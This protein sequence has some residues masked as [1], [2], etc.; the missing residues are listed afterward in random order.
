MLVRRLANTFFLLLIVAIG[1]VA[2]LC[3]ESA[4][5]APRQKGLKLTQVFG[6]YAVTSLK[7][8]SVSCSEDGL[9]DFILT[10]SG[11][12]GLLAKESATL[13]VEADDDDGVY[14]YLQHEEDESFWLFDVLGTTS[15]IKDKVEFVT[16]EAYEYESEVLDDEGNTTVL[17]E[18]LSMDLTFSSARKKGGSASTKSGKAVKVAGAVRISVAVSDFYQETDYEE[19]DGSDGF[20]L[21]E[22]IRNNRDPETFEESDDEEDFVEEDEEPA[23]ECEIEIAFVGWQRK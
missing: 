5:A 12:A 3:L 16:D 1:G 22:F 2:S 15:K 18:G 23:S 14:A 10:E 9:Y 8:K 6:Q 19:E 13:T 11:F 20:N 7:I 4:H 17:S 21:D